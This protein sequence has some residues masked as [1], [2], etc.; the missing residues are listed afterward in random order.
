M[1][2]NV[3]LRVSVERGAVGGPRFMTTVHS[4]LSGHEHRLAEW[5][6]C[7]GEWDISYGIQDKDDLLD[8]VKLFY[9]RLGRFYPFRFKDWSD[10]E[11]AANEAIGTGD[12]STAT[13]QLKKTYTDGVRSYVRVIKLPVSGTLVVKV[14]GVTKTETTHY[15]VNYSTGVITF[16]GGNI[17]SNGHAVT[18]TFQFDVPVR[19]DE[20]HLKVNMYSEDLGQIPA[21]TIVEVLDE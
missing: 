11:S 18:A 9:S 7:R 16:T 19:F 3:R 21:I 5:D 4:A 14:N 6:E 10:F 20:D 17:P 2:D 12:G 15:T 13:F 1:V 8:V